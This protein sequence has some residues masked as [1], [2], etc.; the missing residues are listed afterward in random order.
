MTFDNIWK[1]ELN[2]S[3]VKVHKC[4]CE[5]DEEIDSDIDES[6]N[7]ILFRRPTFYSNI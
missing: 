1:I 7:E 4:N 2:N 5:M 6:E 3:G